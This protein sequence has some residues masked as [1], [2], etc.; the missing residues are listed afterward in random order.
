VGPVGRE[1]IPSEGPK[2]SGNRGNGSVPTIEA[3]LNSSIRPTYW[4]RDFNHPVYN[5]QSLGWE[6]SSAEQPDGKKTYNTKL[7]GYSNSGHYFGNKLSDQ[8]R[9]ALLEYL[10]TL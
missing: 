2:F 8:E 10:K 9:K 1:E 3:V 7:P 4:K 6:F 5:T